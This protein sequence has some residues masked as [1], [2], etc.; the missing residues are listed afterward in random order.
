MRMQYL[1]ESQCCGAGAGR[2]RAF[3]AG[4]ETDFFGSAPPAFLTSEKPY[5]LKIFIFHC[6]LYI[7]LYNESYLLGTKFRLIEPVFIKI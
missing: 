1:D 2:S 5:D 4:A 6:I 7:L 3:L